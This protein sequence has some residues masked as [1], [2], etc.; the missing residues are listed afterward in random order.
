MWMR[1]FLQ[2]QV[3]RIVN[4][5]LLIGG[6]GAAVAAAEYFWPQRTGR[7]S[8]HNYKQVK[9][10]N[11]ATHNDFCDIDFNED[12]EKIP[13]EQVL[14]EA[15]VQERVHNDGKSGKLVTTRF[16][17]S[18][19]SRYQDGEPSCCHSNLPR[20][21]TRGSSSPSRAGHFGNNS[22]TW[23]PSTPQT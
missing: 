5:S 16:V 4:V 2:H 19:L 13:P 6:S 21:R 18:Q 3:T 17:K 15:I 9:N 12:E 1:H 14:L 22:G 11:A 20:E 23:V 7:L 10:V 8:D